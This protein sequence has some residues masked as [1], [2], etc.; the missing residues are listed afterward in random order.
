MNIDYE[1]LR[2]DMI[3]YFG[4]STGI[5]PMAFVNISEFELSSNDKLLEI[6][7]ENG[8]DINKYKL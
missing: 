5:F 6:A 4:T 3:N 1:S 8:I 7:A 2:E